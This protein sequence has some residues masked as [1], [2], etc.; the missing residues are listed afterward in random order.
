M[1]ENSAVKAGIG[2]IIGNYLL[3]GIS[4][5]SVP[6]FAR[7][8]TKEDFG[9]YNTFVAYE[10]ILFVFIGMAIHVSYK[11][12]YFKMQDTEHEKRTYDS[13]VSMTILMILIHAVLLILL[14]VPFHDILCRVLDVSIENIVLIIMYSMASAI[15]TCYNADCSLRYEYT[16]FLL[17]SGFNAILNI[18]L[19]FV[20]IVSLYKDNMYEGRILGTVIPAIIISAYICYYFFHKSLPRIKIKQL[21]WGLK[22]SLPIIPHGI[23]QVILSSFDRIMING[24]IGSKE[25]GIYSFSYSIYTVV[26]VTANSLDSVW[27]PWFYEK[28]NENNFN[29]IKRYSSVIMLLMLFFSI[30]IIMISPEL[31][32][33]FGGEEYQDAIRCVIPL[34]GSGFFSFLYFM[35]AV[36]EYYHCKTR[37]IAVGTC[38]AAVINIMLNYYCINR[39]GYIAAAY[40]TLITYLLYFVFHYTLARIIE[41]EFIYSNKI[42]LFCIL[43]ILLSVFGGEI[44]MDV[45]IIRYIVA[46]LS[47]SCFLYIE[48]KIIGFLHKI[49]KV[50]KK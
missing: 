33:I 29:G 18:F 49:R 12:A 45:H 40:T 48:E 7:L 2:Y 10:A 15:I 21:K 3:K 9:I 4:F 31:I 11:N 41:G 32:F 36:I 25:A 39:Y 26:Q 22:Y 17:A 13:Y 35:P 34:V 23:S 14:V 19:S 16:R 5:F 28:R 6:I 27:S 30:F 47:L 43:L 44:F 42:I 8:M 37:Y 46:F 24:M 50:L 38:S 20:L 1:K